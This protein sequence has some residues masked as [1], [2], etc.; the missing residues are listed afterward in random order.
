[1]KTKK[2][3]DE[4]IE[5]LIDNTAK[6]KAEYREELRDGEI[7]DENCDLLFDQ[8]DSNLDS[9]LRIVYGWALERMSEEEAD[10]LFAKH[11]IYY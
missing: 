6:L 8:A 4:Y 10:E 2:E 9:E 5:E 3:F 11:N 7:T 1:M